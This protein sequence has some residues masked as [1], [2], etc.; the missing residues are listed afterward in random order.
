M[1]I[2]KIIDSYNYNQT[3]NYICT[4]L[5]NYINN[6]KI[7]KYNYDDQ[8]IKDNKNIIFSNSET[9][10]TC[11]NIF[12]LSDIL[13]VQDIINKNRYLFVVSYHN[14]T[15]TMEAG[16]MIIYF[17]DDNKIYLQKILNKYILTS[18]D[19][20]N[21]YLTSKKI[22]FRNQFIICVT[23]NRD[24]YHIL[25]YITELNY[26]DNIINNGYIFSDTISSMFYKPILYNNKLLSV[27]DTCL[28]DISSIIF[29]IDKKNIS[30]DKYELQSKELISKF[31]ENFSGDNYDI[32]Y[33]DDYPINCIKCN[34]LTS[35]IMSHSYLT[36][37]MGN[38][39][40]TNCLIRF[41]KSENKWKCCKSINKNYCFNDLDSNY[42]CNNKHE[43]C[44]YIFDLNRTF[45]FPFKN[46]GILIIKQE[47]ES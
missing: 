43:E 8:I 33:R 30:M 12:N 20:R 10:I 7:K 36:M 39:F 35:I 28:I 41:S 17:N 37:S 42:E 16:G 34:Q 38:S 3:E 31:L 46:C 2:N 45:K 29:D 32:K 9:I 19:D 11:E 14:K 18:Y 25:L 44:K 21:G 13:V 6:L 5:Y 22:F 1:D 47:N 26:N 4:F 24:N 27:S 23:N 15:Y 40:C